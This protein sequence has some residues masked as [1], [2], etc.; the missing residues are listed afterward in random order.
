MFFVVISLAL[1]YFLTRKYGVVGPAYGTLIAICFFNLI[2]FTA[3]WKIY[4]LQPFGFNNLKVIVIALACYFLSLL[5]PDFGNLYINVAVPSLVFVAIYSITIV[6]LNISADIS[7]L[8][9]GLIK[10]FS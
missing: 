6:K 3:I 9:Q 5:I 7:D 8:Y 1:N 10:R 2:R 4:K